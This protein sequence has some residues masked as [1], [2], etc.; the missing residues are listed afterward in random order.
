M[1][2]KIPTTA[3]TKKSIK[4]HRDAL[5]A[6]LAKVVGL[7]TRLSKLTDKHSDLTNQIAELE[8]SASADDAAA[9]QQLVHAREALRIT[10][11]SLQAATTVNVAGGDA[12]EEL[13]RLLG[14]TRDEFTCPAL[15]AV[16][17][18]IV[19]DVAEKFRPYF[20]AGGWALE[21]AKR[22]D[23]AAAFE[24]FIGRSF[25]REPNVIQAHRAI[26]TCDA[27]LAGEIE[28]PFEAD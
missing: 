14:L 24:H 17:A 2:I 25:G 22:C 21:A 3:A 28:F 1:K 13:G 8:A 19:A 26:E 23:L 5:A 6:A 12:G 7:S 11:S 10:E 18:A 4:A 27:I 16:H 15:A 20:R 9:V